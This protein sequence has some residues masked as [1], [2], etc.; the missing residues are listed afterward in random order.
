MSNVIK[1]KRGTASGI[2]T[3]NDGE[4]GWTTDTFRLYVGQGSANKLVG[5]ADFV[6]LAG[7]TLTGFLTLHADPSSDMHP[8]TK[9]YVD[10]LIQGIDAKASVKVAT[11]ENI[12]LSGTQT[13]D[14]VAVS[15]GDRV[16]VK[17]QTTTANN[18]IYVVAA[19]TWA[20]AAD[21][22]SWDELVS[23]YTWVEQGTASGD[24]G[25][26]CTVNAGGT[27]GST[28]VTFVQFS[29]SGQITAGAGLT[30]TGDT[31]DVG[32][33]N[34]ITV[35]TDSI[36]VSA[37]ATAFSFSSGVL[38]PTFGTSSGQ[39]CQGNDSRLHSQNTDTGTTAPSFQIDSDGN[40]P[41][42]GKDVNG[43]RITASDGLNNASIG[44][45]DLRAYGDG[46]SN[47]GN[48]YIYRADGTYYSDLTVG[49]MT[50]N[51]THTLPNITGN[52]L[53]D[54]LIDTAA[55]LK[56][57]ASSPQKVQVNIDATAFSFSSGA[58]TPTFGTGSGQFCQ[59]NDARL[60]SQNT[61][62]GTTGTSFQIDSGNSGPSLKN[63]SGVLETM[64]YTG[65][66]LADHRAKDFQA[67]GGNSSRGAV[68]FYDEDKSHYIRVMS[69]ATNLTANYD[70]ELPSEN[71]TILT[72]VSTLDGGTW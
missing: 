51:R 34:G 57:D 17:N 53:V 67:Y 37:N 61:D 69:D 66:I 42:L 39:F 54:T 10:N 20:R 32:A 56:F 23:L 31:I 11:T 60:H 15:V 50:A 68:K 19:S 40:G 24:T 22:D 27:L 21:A 41:I 59:G 62:T 35:A 16:L 43:V 65:S 14:G 49:T 8:A 4:P 48:V 64:S 5:E 36:A 55:G 13:I 72:N 44:I 33:G 47:A 3:L 28:T 6:K 2:P 38:T 1:F 30:K 58:L 12:T 70:I 46:I 26:L 7:S 52:I 71:G 63:N 9:Q 18:G 45:K 25:W 29:G